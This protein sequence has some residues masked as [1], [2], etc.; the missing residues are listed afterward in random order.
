[1]PAAVAIVSWPRTPP[2]PPP[3]PSTS[4]APRSRERQRVLGSEVAFDSPDVQGD[5]ETGVVQNGGPVLDLFHFLCFFDL[6]PPP[7]PARSLGLLSSDLRPFLGCTRPRTTTRH[8]LHLRV[9]SS[10]CY[11]RFSPHPPTRS[12]NLKRFVF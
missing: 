4:P 6:L 11:F 8:A 9:A 2:P 5:D 7:S 3:P 10:S 12:R 1:M